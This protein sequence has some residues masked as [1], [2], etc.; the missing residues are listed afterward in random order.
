MIL[1]FAGLGFAM[2]DFV[3]WP[4]PL[5]GENPLLDLRGALLLVKPIC[6][7][8]NSVRFNDYLLLL[9]YRVTPLAPLPVCIR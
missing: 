9:S 5:L 4:F 8:R 2:W 7:L 3:R 1:F 6:E